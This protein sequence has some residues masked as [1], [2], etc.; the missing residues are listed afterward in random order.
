MAGPFEALQRFGTSA[1]G[2]ADELMG[3][4]LPGGPIQGEHRI[5][6]ASY[7]EKRRIKGDVLN[8]LQSDVDYYVR[9]GLEPEAAIRLVLGNKRK[10]FENTLDPNSEEGKAIAEGD[11]QTAFG[12]S[13]HNAAN[14]YKY[15]E[16]ATDKEFSDMFSKFGVN[17]SNMVRDFFTLPDAPPAP[18]TPLNMDMY[19]PMGTGETPLNMDMYR[20]MGT[21]GSPLRGYQPFVTKGGDPMNRDMYQPVGTGRNPLNAVMTN[22]K[23]KK[24]AYTSGI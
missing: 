1:Y 17:D 6:L 14:I 3:G 5:P 21:G 18:E 23:K 9:Q 15:F 16:G 10:K 22:A 20:P 8:T 4:A 11:T 12:K 19:I 24:Q 2:R 7:V 13:A